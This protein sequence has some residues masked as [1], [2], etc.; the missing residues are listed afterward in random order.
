MLEKKKD[1]DEYSYLKARSKRL[2]ETAGDLV[3]EETSHLGVS[4]QMVV[5]D[6]DLGLSR[7]L[8]VTASSDIER[9]L[10]DPGMFYG[11]SDEQGDE[12]SD[13]YKLNKPDEVGL[14]FFMDFKI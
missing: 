1:T 10:D 11:G 4:G 12:L 14:G 5:N 3:D 6:F 8:K 2:N 9:R 7:N 13:Y